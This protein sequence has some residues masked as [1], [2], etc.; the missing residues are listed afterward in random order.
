MKSLKKVFLFTVSLCM[1]LTSLTACGKPSPA[2]LGIEKPLSG[3]AIPI[4]NL[5]L[6]VYGDAKI[7][8]ASKIASIEIET[9]DLTKLK[10]GYKVRLTLDTVA[11]YDG[12][13]SSLPDTNTIKDSSI[14]TIEAVL[15]ADSNIDLSESTKYDAAIYLPSKD[16]IWVVDSRCIE[17]GNNNK[18]YAWVSKKSPEEMKPGEED[19]ELVEVKTG[20]TDGKR[21]EVTEGLK[22]YKTIFMH[23]SNL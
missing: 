14:C 1:I 18:T 11:S 7:D 9:S 15:D 5:G 20:E 6:A 8:P 10:A 12:E 2:S 22:E 23:I 17:D 19:W 13:V 4:R 3:G 16:G 21:I